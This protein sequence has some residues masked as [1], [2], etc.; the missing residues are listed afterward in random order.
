ML[1]L[2]AI[3]KEALRVARKYIGARRVDSVLVEPHQDWEGKDSVRITVVLKSSI[4]FTGE[5]VGGITTDLNDFMWRNKDDRFA[6]TH[7]ATVE[8]MEQLSEGR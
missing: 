6:Y 7:Y 1:S 4:E 5:I 8:D 2:A 3:K